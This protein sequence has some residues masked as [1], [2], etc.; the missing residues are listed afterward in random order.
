[1]FEAA[2]KSGVRFQPTYY[3]KF[4]DTALSRM[5]DEGADNILTPKISRIS[6]VLET[7]K[8]RAPS[9]QQMAIVRKQFSNA[10]GS[11]DRAEARLGFNRR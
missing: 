9:I 4:V 8:G 5:V 7:S 1:M 2:E 3:D 11:A 6:D 10:A